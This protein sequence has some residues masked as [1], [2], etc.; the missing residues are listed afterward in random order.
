MPKKPAAL[1][2]WP[3][4]HNEDV[5]MVEAEEVKWFADQAI[6]DAHPELANVSILYVFR[7]DATGNDIV[8]TAKA[9]KYLG[10]VA[11]FDAVIEVAWEAWR[12]LS[13]PAKAGMIDNELCRLWYDSEKGAVKIKQ[14]DFSGFHDNVARHG[15]WNDEVRRLF[16]ANK[17]LVTQLE[18]VMDG[19]A[20]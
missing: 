3:V 11:S 14:P 12:R 1:A 5:E 20:A 4:E 7:K 8:K 6:R 13:D 17:K 9:N 16:A 19:E 2:E 10:F 18:L 15:A